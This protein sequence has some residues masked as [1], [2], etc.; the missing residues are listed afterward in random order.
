MWVPTV[1]FAAVSRGM[2]TDS[3]GT[4][5]GKVQGRAAVEKGLGDWAA[6]DVGGPRV[7]G[8]CGS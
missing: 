7:L 6:S 4:K 8:R 2:L 1:W 3:G 5:K